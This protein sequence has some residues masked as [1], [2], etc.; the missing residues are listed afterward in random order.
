MTSEPYKCA[1]F[2]GSLLL[3]LFLS[4]AILVGS[5]IEY[6]NKYLHFLAKCDMQLAL[7]NIMSASLHCQNKQLNKYDDKKQPIRPFFSSLGLI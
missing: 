1:L 4:K 6:V 3:S 7:L 5:R 2:L